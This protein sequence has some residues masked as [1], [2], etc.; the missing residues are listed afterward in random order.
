MKGQN[1]FP[2]TMQYVIASKAHGKGKAGRESTL[3]NAKP[4]QHPLPNQSAQ[5]AAHYSYGG[6]GVA[7]AAEVLGS[8]N[9]ESEG[10]AAGSKGKGAAGVDADGCADGRV[11][12]E[13]G[14]REGDG[15]GHD[16]QEVGAQLAAV[17]VHGQGEGDD[18]SVENGGEDIACPWKWAN[19]AVAAGFGPEGL[20]S[21]TCP[22]RG[23]GFVNGGRGLA[24]AHDG[25]PDRG[26]GPEA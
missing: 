20:V 4:T 23:Q 10:Q 25:C 22:E 2:L 13:T 8:G 15:R 19:G 1:I 18:G 7:V 3:R 6:D 12:E 17:L 16:R 26:E 11:P 24:V 14:D 5:D 9:G 21:R